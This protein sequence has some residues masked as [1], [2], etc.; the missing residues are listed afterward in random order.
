LD[1]FGGFFDVDA[2]AC[3]ESFDPLED[4]SVFAFFVFGTHPG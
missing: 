3:E 2:V 4:L 1:I